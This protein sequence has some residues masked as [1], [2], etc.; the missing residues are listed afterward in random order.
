MLILGVCSIL[1][2]LKLI[3]L[4]NYKNYLKTTQLEN[5]IN[6]L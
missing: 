2:Y 6:Y 3:K 5:K 1:Y 4:E